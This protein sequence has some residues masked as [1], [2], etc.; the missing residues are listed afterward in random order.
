MQ[1]TIQAEKTIGN[2]EL[3][4]PL[5][6]G[7]HCE[8]YRARDLKL[9]REV[10]LRIL[11]GE[12]SSAA[13]QAD[14]FDQKLHQLAVPNHPNVAALFGWEEAEGK[15]FLLF[16][17]VEGETLAG[18]LKREKLSVEQ[19]LEVCGQIARTLEAAHEQGIFHGNLRSGNIKI[20]P[21]GMVKILNFGIGQLFPIQTIPKDLSLSS[22]ATGPEISVELAACLSP[23]QIKGT[24]PLEA[25]IDIWAFGCIL[26][27]C[28]TGKPPFQRET[29]GKTRD[30]IEQ[31]EPDWSALPSALP[32][33]IRRALKLCLEKDPALRWRNIADAWLDISETVW[34]PDQSFLAQPRKMWIQLAWAMALVAVSIII[35]TLAIKFHR[36]PT[37]H[38]VVRSTIKLNPGLKFR[39]FYDLNLPNCSAFDISADGSFIVYSALKRDPTDGR[40]YLR[41]VGEV[42]AKTI[43]GTEDAISPFIS[44]DGK[45]IGFWASQALKKIPIEGG[46]PISICSLVT[47]HVFSTSESMLFGASWINEKEIIFSATPERGLL[48]VSAAGGKPETITQ[49][50]SKQGE[51][52]HIHPHALPGGKQALFTL[53]HQPYDRKPAVALLDLSTKKYRILL[54]DGAD[55]RYVATGHLVFMRETTLMAVPFA[56][57]KMELTGKPSPVVSNVMRVY[58][59]YVDWNPAA[60][61]FSI[62]HNG[63]LVYLPGGITPPRQSEMIWAGVDGS[64]EKLASFSDRIYFLRLSPDFR[65]IAYQTF[66]EGRI[67]IYDLLKRESRPVTQDGAA[68]S[69]V[70]TPDSQGVIL[71]YG[72]KGSNVGNLYLK[73]LR[74]NAPLEQ[75]TSNC[76]WP[77]PSSMSPDGEWLAFADS[78]DG[79]KNWDIK[80][81]RMQDRK[82]IPLVESPR[83]DWLAEF[84]PDG[85]W[86]LFGSLGT[87][88]YGSFVQLFPGPGGKVP[89]DLGGGF[90]FWSRDGRKIL[91]S[92]DG[93]EF[94]S[95]DVRTSPD[96]SVGQSR[97]LF[98]GKEFYMS[99]P[100]RS[101]DV[102]ADGKKFLLAR[103]S[104][105]KFEVPT[106]MILVQ[107]WFEDLKRLSPSR[108]K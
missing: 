44:P 32:F 2:Y 71:C 45:W 54:E 100:A 88:G 13:E 74:E 99:T 80:L 75:L 62:S 41:K 69:V 22:E 50:V 24:V 30:A 91:Y 92:P 37:A 7:R 104:D 4:E 43:E 93:L 28:L 11:P 46:E 52:S 49:P 108:K 36:S 42:E 39:G 26:Y 106:E 1:N 90:G 82:I 68:G 8:V 73:K 105:V 98:K 40:L 86:L 31:D 33:G 64:V 77:T 57:Q 55:A 25:R 94:R 48:R 72:K 20:T 83:H 67:W 81:L 3:L 23:E 29:V 84:S 53:M 95:V 85:R 47:H 66:G 96:F 59:D 5:G 70:W 15:R 12:F 19:T 9:H 79:T 58:I 21:K 101:F 103:S 6:S 89:I 107:N 63:S 10:A 60:G 65:Q 38:S 76:S 35:T 27:E 78:T 17:L 16:E 34:Q 102:S 18:L 87:M 61:L 56:L 14:L 51:F 97:R